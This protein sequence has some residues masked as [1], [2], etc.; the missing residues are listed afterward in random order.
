M[1]WRFWGW[2]FDWGL[3]GVEG[4]VLGVEVDGFGM[5]LAPLIRDI[6]AYGSNLGDYAGEEGLLRNFAEFAILRSRNLVAYRGDAGLVGFCYSAILQDL[7]FCGVGSVD[8][9]TWWEC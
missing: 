7:R 4:W 5:V 8:S 6:I 3:S 1:I 9:R 2:G